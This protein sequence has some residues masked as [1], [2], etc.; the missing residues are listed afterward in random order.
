[1]AATRLRSP[2]GFFGCGRR[3]LGSIVDSVRSCFSHRRFGFPLNR[4]SRR[5]PFPAVDS[6]GR[7]VEGLVEV[8]SSTTASTVDDLDQRCHQDL[9]GCGE[10]RSA[11]RSVCVVGEFVQTAIALGVGRRGP[12]RAPSATVPR[13]SFIS[14]LTASASSTSERWIA[15]RRF[16]IAAPSCL[17]ARTV[18][19]IRRRESGRRRVRRRQSPRGHR[20]R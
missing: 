11:C 3:A 10:R 6:V 9:V 20:T 18:R 14:T 2:V 15:S 4:A 12:H 16:E 13:S 7:P 17:L 8:A 1:M 19:M 5:V